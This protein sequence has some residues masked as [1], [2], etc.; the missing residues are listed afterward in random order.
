[1]CAYF[2][3]SENEVSEAMKQAAKEAF[4]SNKT[5]VEQMWSIARACA[6]KREGLSLFCRI[7]CLPKL[8]P[9]LAV[10]AN[11]MPLHYRPLSRQKQI[12]RHRHLGRY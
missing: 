11:S 4:N 6:R 1:M 7:V 9:L 12:W 10:P 8:Y 3:K 2:S 5:N